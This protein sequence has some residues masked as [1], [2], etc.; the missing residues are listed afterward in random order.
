MLPAFLADA[1]KVEGEHRRVVRELAA[2]DREARDL[3][4]QGAAGRTPGTVATDYQVEGG[5]GGGSTDDST[6]QAQ[7]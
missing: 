6:L 4:L 1:D 7:L 3:A 2:F 5:A